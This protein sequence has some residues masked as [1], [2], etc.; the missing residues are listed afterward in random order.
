[1]RDRIWLD[2][3]VGIE[4]DLFFVRGV[5]I[6]SGQAELNLFWVLWSIDLVFV[7]VVVVEI[8]SVFG[9]GPQIAW[10]IGSIEIDLWF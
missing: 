3:G 9:C 7:W 2:F 1:M 8:A 10:F 6:D 4:S 5:E